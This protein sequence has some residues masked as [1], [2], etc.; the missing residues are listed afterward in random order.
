MIKE[1][2]LGQLKEITTRAD[3]IL[4]LSILLLSILMFFLTPKIIADSGTN[5]QI[6][7]TLDDQE[8]YR[9]RLEKDNRLKKIKFDFN[10]EGETY[11]GVLRIKDGKVKLDR[12]SQDISPLPIHSNM[13][14]IS[15]P[16]QVIV[17]LPIKLSVT[18]ESNSKNEEEID[19]MS[20]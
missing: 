6:V 1:L 20:F 15:E 4:I 18:I 7:I 9:Y 3:K 2:N 12:L 11:Q 14:W 10:F 17:C 8:L 16:Y 5:K 19:I 13:G